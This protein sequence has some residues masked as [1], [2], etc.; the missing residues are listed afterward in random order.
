MAMTARS[1]GASPYSPA[2]RRASAQ[3]A[4]KNSP[5]VYVPLSATRNGRSPYAQVASTNSRSVRGPPAYSGL[6]SSARTTSKGAPGAVSAASAARN[7]SLFGTD[8]PL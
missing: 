6:P 8:K 5:Y 3:A 1:P 7:G 2:N 4:A